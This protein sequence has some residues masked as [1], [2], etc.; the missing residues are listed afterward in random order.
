LGLREFARWPAR[1]L[2]YGLQRRVELARAV[3][4]DPVLLMLDEPLA[5][6]GGQEANE[7][8]RLVRDVA[9]EGPS[10]L[11]VEHHVESV[12]AF[13]DRVLVLNFGELIADGPPDSV[14]H[15][16]AVIEAYL[17]ADLE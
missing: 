10:V 11:F 3:A 14:R 2:P 4:A 13:S 7:V 16:P 9:A 1:A 12:M 15:D 17:G 5:G 6:L 8:G